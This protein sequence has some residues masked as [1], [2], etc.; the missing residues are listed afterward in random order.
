[1]A[2]RGYWLLELVSISSVI[3][4]APAQY[5]RAY[6]YTETDDSDATYFLLHQLNALKEAIAEL[7]EY[8]RR[9]VEE[10]R[11]AQ[12]LIEH[13]P[14]LH[15][16]LNYR[17]LALIDHAL[18]NPQS[19]YRIDRHQSAHHVTYQT[20]RTD[21]LDLVDLGLLGKSKAGRAFIFIAPEDLRDRLEAIKS[22]YSQTAPG[23]S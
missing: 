3:K 9:K 20:A 7:H 6:L 22:G 8:L 4:R 5:V 1:M 2:Q 21:L 16:R 19:V 10:Q 17:Q 18:R 11:H 23:R 13:S 15:E 14:A 12:Q